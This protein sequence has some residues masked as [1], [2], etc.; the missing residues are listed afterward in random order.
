MM[1]RQSALGPMLLL[2]ALFAS[3]VA[4]KSSCAAGRANPMLHVAAGRLVDGSARPLLLRCVNL[5]P[6]LIPEGYLMGQG[7]LAA[8]T[9]SPSQIK[10]RLEAVVGPQESRAFWR[11]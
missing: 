5:S 9:T 10:R 6:W 3:G 11:S 2:I 4:T 8:L 7:S 1:R